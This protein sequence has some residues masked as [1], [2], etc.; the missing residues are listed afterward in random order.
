MADQVGDGGQVGHVGHHQ[1]VEV[2]EHQMVGA[3][4][5][6]VDAVVESGEEAF[7]GKAFFSTYS[8]NPTNNTIAA[9]SPLTCPL[10]VS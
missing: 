10:D 5:V 9:D 1:L 4:H 6:A 3:V 7:A 8:R 2:D